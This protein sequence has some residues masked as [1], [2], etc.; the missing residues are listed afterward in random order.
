MISH[1]SP[2]IET[3]YWTELHIIAIGRLMERTDLTIC[4]R[5]ELRRLMR[6]QA[7]DKVRA[8]TMAWLRN[9]EMGIAKSER[10][11]QAC[12]R[13]CPVC[14]YGKVHS[15]KYNQCRKCRE[16]AGML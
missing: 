1:E 12:N 8:A 16:K 14:K 15:K 2:T 5:A 3:G 4:H 6:F 11:L 10:V 9:L 7:G 13:R